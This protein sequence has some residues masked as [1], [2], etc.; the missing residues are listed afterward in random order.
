MKHTILATSFAATFATAAVLL[1]FL[2]APSLAEG[3]MG[4]GKITHEATAKECSACHMAFQPQLLPARSW[5][6]IM[7][8]LPNHFGED[9]TLAPEIA[10]DI[11]AYLVANAGDVKGNRWMKRIAADETP[12][13]ITETQGWIRAHKGEVRE[14]SFTSDKVKSKAN[15]MACHRGADQ[16][17]FG[18]D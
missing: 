10:A 8:D 17:F 13:R 11:K 6:A 4:V 16:G 15:C 1:P 5:E 14:S 7:N 2:P 3:G 18:D 9:A 12:L